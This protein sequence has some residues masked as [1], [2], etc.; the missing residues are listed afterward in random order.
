MEDSSKS[1]K[2]VLILLLVL[3]ISIGFA[4]LST[5][6]NIFGT[7]EIK[8][9]SWNIYFDN[10]QVTEGSVTANT[11]EIDEDKTTVNYTVTL[12][13]PGDF[14]EFTIDAKNDGTLNGVIESVAISELDADVLKYLNYSVTYLDG[15][16]IK[17]EDILEA[18]KKV[19]YKILIE[20]KKDIVASDL[21]ENGIDL[22]LSFT[23]NYVQATKK[24]VVQS[25]FIKLVKSSV[26]SD[27]SINFAQVSSD[28]NGKGLYMLSST[29]NDTSP[30][31]YYRG[32]VTNNNA[33]FA[34]FCWKIVRTTSTGGTKLVYNGLPNA[35]GE[36][37][38]TTGTS[39]QLSTKSEYNTGY[40]SPA[41][42]GYMY[43]D[44]YN[45]YYD[46]QINTSH[47]YGNS[48]T[49]NNGVYTLTDTINGAD[50]THHYTCFNETGQCSELSY[51]FRDFVQ[52]AFYLTLKDGKSVEDALN[53]MYTNTTNSNIKTTVDNWF[54]NTFLT[55][56]TEQGKDYNNYLED[57]IWCN[58]RSMNIE[59][60]EE[61]DYVT[62]NGW[63]PNGGRLDTTLIYGAYGRAFTGKPSVSCPNKN[64][65]FTVNDT[66]N[67]NG[68]LT[69]PV[70]LLTTDEV[71]LAG[72]QDMTSGNFYLN[73]DQNW[74]TMSPNSFYDGGYV[75]TNSYVVDEYKRL[76]EYGVTIPIG[77]RPSISIAPSVKI[78]EGGDGSSSAPYEFIVE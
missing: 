41:Y 17:E 74:W 56:F 14:Y 70:G 72:G 28:N 19:T 67:G 42:N 4:Y 40:T 76:V 71:V 75:Y 23:V 60:N 11:P 20:Y 50:T 12:D 47:L 22:E 63:K 65:A 48:F 59:E 34:G 43:G 30:V 31:Y 18:K 6:L 44:V 13:K 10:V 7:T 61:G 57:T 53:E 77:V 16:E 8:A 46:K 29:K 52:T 37:T 55:Y 5:Q 3:F 27:S 45:C 78:R 36:C 54:S 51:V 24:T 9:N 58:D 38:N 49:Y 2:N 73:T 32:E 35:N 62:N 66:V 39:T 68:A 21:D 33:L 25:E 69:Y 1:T 15:T 64:D 26:L